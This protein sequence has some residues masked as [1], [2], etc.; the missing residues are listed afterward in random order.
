MTPDTGHGARYMQQWIAD[1]AHYA[2]MM[3][4]GWNL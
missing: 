3:M 2:K 1:Q 4:E